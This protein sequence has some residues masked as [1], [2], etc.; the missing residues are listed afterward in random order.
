MKIDKNAKIYIAGHK[1]M[2]GSSIVRK[3]T[4]EG[5]TNLI[6]RSLEELDL[7]DQAKVKDFF[8]TEKPEY[9][10]LAAAR[11]GGIKANMTYPSEFLY[12]NLQIQNNVIWA[13]HDTNVKKLMLL[14]TSCVYPRECPQPMEE[15]YLMTGALEP[16]NEGYAL[17]KI[18]GIKMCQSIFEQYKQTFISCM[19]TNIYGENDYYDP[20][21]AHAL[22]ALLSR[23]HQAK[24]DDTKEVVVWG[25]GKA[26][27]EWLYVDDLA[28]AVF[29][30]MQNYDQKEFVNVGTGKDHSIKELA[31]MIAQTVGYKG[32]LVFDTT[33]PD[34]MPQ[35]LLDVSKMTSL[36]WKAKI[37]LMTGLKKT[38]KLYLRNNCA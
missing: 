15:E 20:I 4:K 29:W 38:Y 22:P 7:L 21:K 23:I 31:E 13:A 12:E 8:A 37:D 9:V 3:F 32:K 34:G 25:T 24:V 11:V 6:T 14:G 2:V 10:I 5:Y 17:A 28:D 35:K 19:P 33:K 36:G 18:T 27:R 16:T 26:R 1:G 30:M